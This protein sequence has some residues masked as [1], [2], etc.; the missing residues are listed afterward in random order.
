[1]GLASKRKSASDSDASSDSAPSIKRHA[2]DIT[3]DSSAAK[4]AKAAHSAD[5]LDLQCVDAATRAL[6]A[7]SRYLDTLYRKEPGSFSILA[8]NCMFLVS[9][10]CH[11]V[12][13]ALN[14][15]VEST[16]RK[17]IKHCEAI[18]KSE[19]FAD[20]DPLLRLDTGAIDGISVFGVLQYKRTLMALD[21]LSPK[22][23]QQQ[24]I[25]DV[26][27]MMPQYS[28]NETIRWPS[29]SVRTFGSALPRCEGD[30]SVDFD[31]P[32][33]AT[34]WCGISG[35]LT[36]T[37][38]TFSDA[39]LS[40]QQVCLWVRLLRVEGYK[41]FA[42]FGDYGA[43]QH[44]TYFLTHLVFILCRWGRCSLKNAAFLAPERDA[45]LAALPVA[46]ARKDYELVS[47]LV[48]VC[49]VFEHRSDTVLAAKRLLIK[50]QNKN[51]QW[52]ANTLGCGIQHYDITHTL[53]CCALA[54]SCCTFDPK[55]RPIHDAF[56]H[57][58]I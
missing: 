21:D 26:K 27:A 49:R 34:T 22:G 19:Q 42:Q 12:P 48:E 35:D 18:D 41:T 32:T 17:I 33:Q 56:K 57:L 38:L 24:L 23:K 8:T 14:V 6:Q 30:G 44:Q 20:Q 39:T 51:G 36:I 7:M 15:Q 25:D 37:P 45:A 13:W 10:L 47:E 29:K 28:S 40:M 53:F 16:V 52:P 46:L 55:T 31:A 54:L 3:G 43:L 9:R 58:L 50:D 11:R 2:S 4:S 1:M 5:A